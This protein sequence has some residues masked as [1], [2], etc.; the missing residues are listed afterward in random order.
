M[1]SNPIRATTVLY[2]LLLL[3]PRNKYIS[4]LKGKK[5]SPFKGKPDHCFKEAG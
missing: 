2:I 4:L 1:G 5:G 3:I